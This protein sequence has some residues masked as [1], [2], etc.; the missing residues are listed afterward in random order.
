MLSFEPLQN[1]LINSKRPILVSGPCSAESE[2]QVLA[3]A[4]QLQ[5]LNI[6]LYRAGIWKPRTRPGAFEG[7][8]A[9][10]LPWLQQVKQQYG[11]KV[12]V[13]VANAQHV[14]L[15]LEHGI[16][17]LWIGA[18]STANPFTVQ[19][20]ANA[21]KG[22]DIPV[23]VKNPINPDLNLW[24]GAIERLYN[25]GIHKMI[26]I[27]RGFSSFDKV[28][29]RNKPMWEIPIE[30][31][32]LF[33][34]LPLICDPSH[35]TGKRDWLQ[36]VSQKAYDLNF[37]GLMIESHIDPEKALSDNAQ[38]I[39]PAALTH[40]LDGLI[41]RNVASDDPLFNSTLEQMRAI[42]DKIDEDLIHALHERMKI[43]AQIGQLKQEQN[44]TIL[45]PERWRE[46]FNTRTQMAK[47]NQLSDDLVLRIFQLI[48][49]ESIRKQTEVM[50]QEKSTPAD[51]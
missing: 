46:I 17:V 2:T 49:Q 44:I 18:R 50:K 51:K 37:D 7:I 21:L 14:E 35:I 22:V 48:H 38:Q 15:C 25:A 4:E 47:D 26:A 39:T 10:G 6:D 20:I 34:D 9:V 36:E 31:K 3:V 1:W 12:T 30:L 45:Q 19:E 16:D 27:H 41:V 40:L 33:P 28:Q 11:M 24:V 8:G 43:V 32:Q 5:A 42:I 29:Y 13:E 23:M